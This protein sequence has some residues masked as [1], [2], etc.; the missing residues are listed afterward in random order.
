MIP[1]IIA[2]LIVGAL[3]AKRKPKHPVPPANILQAL[4]QAAKNTGV[5]LEI[6]IGVA[7]TESRYDPN[8]VSP[9]GAQG[10]MQLMPATATNLGVTNPFDPYQSA[11]GGARYL[12]KYYQVYGDWGTT[13]ASYNW[14]PGNVNSGK[15]WPTSV[16]TYVK[17]VIG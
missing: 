12:K 9:V 3:L 13:L 6:L 11:L 2:G 17:N 16:Q 15:P 1:W 14:G 7:H 4:T 10:L 8:A 5:P